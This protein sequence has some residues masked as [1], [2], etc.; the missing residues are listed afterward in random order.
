MLDEEKAPD[1]LLPETGV[2][3]E[4]E[5]LIS[6]IFIKSAVYGT[7]CTTVILIDYNDHVTFAEKRYVGIEP[8][9]S[10]FSFKIQE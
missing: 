8:H 9:Q 4:T 6:S 2:G 7:V 10:T 1:D 5:K 3:Y